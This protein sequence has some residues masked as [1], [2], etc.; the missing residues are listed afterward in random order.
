MSQA[1]TNESP[2]QTMPTE[3]SARIGPGTQEIQTS[4]I[5]MHDV[6]DS[7]TGGSAFPVRSRQRPDYNTPDGRMIYQCGDCGKKDSFRANEPI[8]CRSCACRV[9]HKVRT[10]RL[11][12]YKA[13]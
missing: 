3:T 7:A 8:R 1:K 12:H 6:P 11:T 10:T 4:Y 13:D 2:P 5:P 9:F